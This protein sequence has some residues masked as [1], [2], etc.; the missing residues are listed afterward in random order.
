MSFTIDIPGTVDK[1]CA[2]AAGPLQS[3]GQQAADYASHEFEQFIEDLDHIQ[4][5]LSDPDPKKRI[6]QEDAQYYTDL[7][8]S[9]MKAVL[10][11]IQ[12]LGVIAVQN[13]IN[14]ALAVLTTTLAAAL[15]V[16]LL[17]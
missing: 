1:M 2:A 4:D 11:T 16:A 3:G 9:S 5:L 7:Q 13:A 14:A 10:L 8:K 12:G 17:P 15:K 6:S